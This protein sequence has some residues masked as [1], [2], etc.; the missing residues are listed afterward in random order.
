LLKKNSDKNNG[1]KRI[2]GKNS[3]QAGNPRAGSDV[4]PY[5]SFFLK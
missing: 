5:N 4:R 2:Q 3:R 1:D